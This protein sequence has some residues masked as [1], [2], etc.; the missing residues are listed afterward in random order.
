MDAQLLK[1]LLVED[2]FKEAELL[3][4]FLSEARATRFELTHVQRL[5]ETLEVLEQDNFDVILLD[6]SLPDS[7]GLETVARVRSALCSTTELG[8]AHCNPNDANVSS[9]EAAPLTLSSTQTLSPAPLTPIVV[10]TGLDDENLAVHAIR[11][12]AQ[13][14]LIKGQVDYP[15]LVHALRYAIERTQMSQKLRQSE[16]QYALAISGGQV[17]VWQVNFLSRHIYV[18]PN[19]K[20]LL[21]YGEQEIVVSPRDWLERVH[22][23]DL[24]RLLTAAFDH[25][26]GLTSHIE[27]EHRLLHKDGSCRWV[28][29]R[30]TAF[31]NATGQPYRIA[32]SSTDI[33]GRKQAEEKIAKR[34]CYLAAIVEVQQRLLAFKDKNNGYQSILE[35]LGQATGASRVYIFENDRDCAGQLLMRQCAE[36]CTEDISPKTTDSTL[37]SWVYDDFFPRWAQMLGQGEIVAGI[38]ADFPESERMILEPQG[39]LSILILPLQVLGEF[40]GFIGFDNCTEAR[41]WEASEVAL[42]QA[43][44]SAISLWQERASAEETL[45]SSEERFR[46]LVANIPGAVYRAKNDSNWTM[47]FISEA[48]ADISGYPAADFV[49]NQVRPFASIVHPDD[50]VIAA[51][52]VQQ[53]RLGH[54]PYRLEYR[55]LHADGSIKWVDE[56]GQIVYGDDGEVVWLD[57]VILDIS[58][59]KQAETVL[60]E[61]S[62]QTALAAAV[63]LALTQGGT[64]S[65]MLQQ[66]AQ[67]IVQHL[68]AALARILLLN[69]TENRLELQTSAGMYNPLDGLPEFLPIA[70]FQVDRITQERQPYLTN[71]LL[72]EANLNDR[73]WLLQEGIVAFV[74]YP[75]VVENQLIGVMK[76]F[77]HQP[78]TEATFH[79]LASVADEIALG[80]E[81]KQVEQALE[82]ERQQLRDIIANAP[83]AMA[84]FDTQMRYLV[85]S[86]KWLTDYGLEGHSLIGRNFYEVFPDF[87]K[88]GRRVIQRALQGEVL[89]R[90]EDMWKRSDG[91]TVFIRWAIQPWTT[92]EGSVGGL[93]VVTDRINELVE[94][95]EAALENSRLKSQFLANMSHE[96]R[97]PM[98]GVLGMTELLLK[99]F[100]NPEQLD[101]VQTLRISAENLLTLLNDILDF[102]KL[103]AGEMRLETLEL[104]L[105]SCL[106][107]VAD[108]LGT[109][110]QTKGLELAV[111][112]D[113]NV[114]RHLKGDASR[115]RQILTN[116]VGNA[117][118]FTPQGEV[119]IQASLDFET[120]TYAMIRFAVTD[121]GIGIAPA[122]QKKLFQSFSQVDTST[123]RQYGGTGLGLAICKQLVELMGGEIGVESQGAVFVPGRWSVDTASTQGL[124]GTVLR[125]GEEE[126]RDV[127][128]GSPSESWARPSGQASL[129][130]ADLPTHRRTTDG[131]SYSFSFAKGVGFPADF[132]KEYGIGERDEQN[133]CSPSANGE[134]ESQAMSFDQAS[135]QD[136]TRTPTPKR[137]REVSV[138]PGS[139]RQTSRSVTLSQKPGSTFWFTVPL[140]KQVSVAAAPEPANLA[141]ADIRLLIVSGNATIRKV[142]QSLASFWG[143][144]VEEASTCTEAVTIWHSL[145][146]KNQF[147]DVAIV[148]LNLLQRGTESLAQLFVGELMVFQTKWLLM[149]SVNQR[150]Q[151]ERLLE[152]GFSGCITKPL[153]AS[154]LLGCLRQVL[155]VVS[156]STPVGGSLTGH[157]SRWNVESLGDN[158]P[159]GFSS[160]I[161]P[162]NLPTFN[163]STAHRSKVKI[164]LVEDTLINQKVVLTQLKVLGYEADCV[165]NGQEAIERLTR[166]TGEVPV[167]LSN[168]EVL[169]RL[170]LHEQATTVSGLYAPDPANAVTGEWERSQQGDNRQNLPPRLQPT[171]LTSPYPRTTA[172]YANAPSASPYD[173]VLMDCQMPVMDGYEATRLLRAFEGESRRTV[174]IAMTASAMLG[175]R[176]KCLAADM[177]DYISKPVTLK[178]LEAVL[179]RWT[180]QLACELGNTGP[181]MP[182]SRGAGKSELKTLPLS[183]AKSQNSELSTAKGSPVSTPS[184][185]S[186]SAPKHLNEVPVNLEQL[187]ELSRGDV[188]FQRELLQVFIEDA[189]LHLEDIK[190]A[191]SAGDLITIIRRAHQL[192]GSSATVAIYKMPQIAARLE[193]QAEENQLKDAAGLVTELEQILERV[194]AFIANP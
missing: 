77:F 50:R 172:Y 132:P 166:C 160:R 108:L 3:K 76:L 33:T 32:G 150:S 187:E 52:V 98:N 78:V 170:S 189:L 61:R 146:S 4:E 106:E 16:E 123:T 137:G 82:R 122:N 148:D 69:P 90:P 6:L 87:P 96:I 11:S 22:P 153:K 17:G 162:A 133:S 71:N 188:E 191:L 184:Q 194:Q 105:N 159:Y 176:E 114:P 164:L 161:Q 129:G 94:A 151:A 192:K 185:L 24:Q 48:I 97:T 135:L 120:P 145:K 43:A 1:V 80:I 51:Q 109:P 79:A 5:D 139:N 141:L 169:A 74:G 20:T 140:A 89:S 182:A 40:K 2:N 91:S 158:F 70:R 46:T 58:D 111:L 193:S 66:C 174:V 147:I 13:D 115:L 157:R 9:S 102:S 86:Q 175:D 39:I 117:I 62:R 138:S 21:G 83:V 177:D 131:Y 34:E 7:Q 180:Q 8:S 149:N 49:N 171:T 107:D 44:A 57:G 155:N 167:S 47:S 152:L 128:P 81:R 101:F 59:R 144:R 130:D 38:V 103:E 95:R 154:K 127:Q 30:G 41:A 165:S 18:S 190:M 142:V 143:M 104:D 63:G 163:P 92:P 186:S 113:N 179:E 110:A 42:L 10:L 125:W 181:E 116:L 178:D 93:V 121:T 119:V 60:V 85:H 67:A 25:L 19:M 36:W 29:S 28:L 124:E 15:L 12:G 14:Y 84:M 54:T 134:M 99:T 37:N 65:S 118:K 53:A 68:D 55:I 23:D 168:R 64:L 45:S 156:D 88:R 173:I 100:L 72:D 183:E 31:R 56:Q 126:S 26:Q 27:I 35:T 136:T 73:E 75:L 112:I